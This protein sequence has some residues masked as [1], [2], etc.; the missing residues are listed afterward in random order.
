MPLLLNVEYR[1]L[2]NMALRARV[3]PFLKWRRE[4]A[5]FRGSRS[6]A[7]IRPARFVVEMRGGEGSRQRHAGGRDGDDRRMAQGEEET[8]SVGSLAFLHVLARKVVDGG[9]MVGID[10]VTQAEPTGQQC[11]AEQQRLVAKNINNAHACSSAE[12]GHQ[13]KAV[14]R[15]QGAEQAAN[16]QFEHRPHYAPDFVGPRRDCLAPRSGRYRRLEK[17]A[18]VPIVAGMGALP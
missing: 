2:Q 15:D 6:A 3:K 1:H 4:A 14:D 13:Q 11:R 10:R 5:D 12:I 16:G 8:N 18:V 17:A 7:I 9:D